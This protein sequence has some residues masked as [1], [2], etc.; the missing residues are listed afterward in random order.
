MRHVAAA[1]SEALDGLGPEREDPR[2]DLVTQ[3]GGPKPYLVKKHPELARRVPP[4]ADVPIDAL[5]TRASWEVDELNTRSRECECC[6]V[7]NPGC[8]RSK[9]WLQPGMQP[10]FDMD[11]SDFDLAQCSTWPEASLRNRLELHGVERRFNSVDLAELRA[12]S[13]HQGNE[14]HDVWTAA[15]RACVEY[16]EDYVSRRARGEGLVLVGEAGSGKT[17][18][19]AGVVRA[20][21]QRHT[22]FRWCY[23]PDLVDQARSVQREDAVRFVDRLVSHWEI[24]VLDG[25]GQ[26]YASE[27]SGS[28]LEQV[29]ERRHGAML[30][31][32][33]TSRAR[34]ADVLSRSMSMAATKTL[35]SQSV[36]R[37][38]SV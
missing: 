4:E 30:P 36:V 3:M 20:L 29:V 18:L 25:L 32:L 35:V 28:K 5:T 1:M 7:E 24:L 26:E 33:V 27:F 34:S 17:H 21:A 23:V 22:R 31:T 2:V 19:I 10:Y 8:R 9:L 16:V 13:T 15:H 37:T 11:T 12:P 14:L 6:V 38:L